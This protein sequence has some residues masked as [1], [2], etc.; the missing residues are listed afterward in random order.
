ME[1][2]IATFNAEIVTSLGFS[3]IMHPGALAF[4][5]DYLFSEDPQAVIFET[6]M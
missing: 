2:L 1:L 6:G 5:Y 3:L 4:D